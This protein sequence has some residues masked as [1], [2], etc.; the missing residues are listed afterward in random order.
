MGRA[1]PTRYSEPHIRIVAFSGAF[2]RAC[3]IAPATVSSACDPATNLC[4]SAGCFARL[5]YGLVNMN[6]RA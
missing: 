1:S 4:S 3:S 6:C 5:L 2:V